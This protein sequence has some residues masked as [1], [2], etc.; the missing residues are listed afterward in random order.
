L[1]VHATDLTATGCENAG[2]HCKVTFGLYECRVRESHHRHHNRYPIPSFAGVI[3]MMSHL[4]FCLVAVRVIRYCCCGGRGVWR[5]PAAGTATAARCPF[6]QSAAQSAPVQTRIVNG[7]ILPQNAP[8]AGPALAA[9]TATPAPTPT[10]PAPPAP[11]AVPAIGVYPIGTLA[12]PA[13]PAYVPMSQPEADVQLNRA[14]ALSEE[15]EESDQLNR[16]LALSLAEAAGRPC[17]T[18]GA[19]N[20]E[21]HRFCSAC[22]Q[23]LLPGVSPAAG[24][25]L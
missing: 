11:A 20:P 13:A 25:Q 15:T 23:P 21:S 19:A 10:A 8:S 12:A 18:C 16:V 22:G 6:L 24:L 7:V 9:T 3:M 5:C 2:P 17:P 14:L 1:R 4:C